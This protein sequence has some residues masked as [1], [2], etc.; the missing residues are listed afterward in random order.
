MVAAVTLLPLPAG[1]LT[2]ST[3]GG[4]DAS[5]HVETIVDGGS[6]GLAATVQPDGRIVVAGATLVNRLPTK[7]LL[8][9]YLADGQLDTGFDSDGVV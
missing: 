2:S 3:S 6:E 7:V 4:F 8:A 5:G 1:A 9:R